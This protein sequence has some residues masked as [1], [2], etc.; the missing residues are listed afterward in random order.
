MSTQAATLERFV[1]G[2]Q[3][4]RTLLPHVV[5]IASGKGG[6]GASTIAAM[7]AL[8]AQDL[9]MKQVTLVDGDENLGSLHMLLGLNRPDVPGVITRSLTKTIELSGLG[10]AAAHDSHAGR[11]TSLQRISSTY[12]SADL[13]V[14]DAGSRASAMRAAISAGTSRVI[15]VTTMDPVALAS[16]YA[17]MKL[18]SSWSAGLKFDVLVN[19][20]EAASGVN[21][22]NVIECAT[23]DFLGTTPTLMGTIPHHEHYSQTVFS[24]ALSAGFRGD[25]PFATT[26]RALA[27]YVVRSIRR[28]N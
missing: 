5:T 28:A 9:G 27:Q 3:H 26:S 18:A 2:H 7:A 6:S 16:T 12:E 15:L 17:L 21:A 8:G 20:A 14:I 11:R 25:H 4:E 19:C 22:F 13:V 23:R 1:R 10:A 24:D